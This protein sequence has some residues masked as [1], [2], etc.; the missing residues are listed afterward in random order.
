MKK[1]GILILI[2]SLIFS[3][4][5]CGGQ[6]AATESGTDSVQTSQRENTSS[7]DFSTQTDTDTE[8]TLSSTGSNRPSDDAE[9]N[10]SGARSKNKTWNIL[11]IGNSYTYYNDMPTALFAPLAKS[12]GYK[13]S[14]TAI[15]KGSYYLSEFANP[16]DEY[17]KK[18]QQALSK[19]D[20]DIIILQEQSN[21]AISDP[22]R[23]YDAVREFKAMTEGKDTEIYLYATWGYEEGH[24]KLSNFGTDTADM[25]MKLRAAYTAIAEELDLQ[26]CHVGAAVTYAKTNGTKGLYNEDHTHPSLLGSNIAAW[27][28]FSTVFGVAPDNISHTA[29]SAV[30]AAATFAVS[31]VTVDAAYKTSSEGIIRT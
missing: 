17:G 10:D 8:T 30:R 11:F 1:I 27:T 26:V 6:D 9:N 22:G 19:K 29:A 13:V 4:C 20:Y 5:A 3:L 18:V 23:F 31:G 2:L 21:C 7:S 24:K 25:E 12:A 14:V 28:I 16:E 15:T